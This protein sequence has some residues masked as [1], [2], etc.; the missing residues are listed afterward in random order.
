MPSPLTK[1][2]RSGTYMDDTAFYQD[3]GPCRHEEYDTTLPCGSTL[4]FCDGKMD[5]SQKGEIIVHLVD[6]YAG[7]FILLSLVFYFIC[8]AVPRFRRIALQA[9]VVPIAF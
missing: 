8:L 7:P 4:V 1:R 2:L 9:L 6:A 3:L 5:A